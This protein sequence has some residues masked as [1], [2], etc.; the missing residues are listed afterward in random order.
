MKKTFSVFQNK[1]FTK[2]FIAAVTSHLGTIV[3]MTAFMFYLLE[4]FSSQPFYATFTEMMYSAPTLFVFFLTGVVA[5]RMDRQKVAIYADLICAILSFTL[6]AAVLTEWMPLVF[7]V[8]F[9][10]SGIA[11]FFDPAEKSLVQGILQEEEYKTAAGLNQMVAGVFN[12]FATG[13]GLVAYWSLGVQGAIIADGI[14]FLVSAFLIWS[15][16]IDQEARLPNGS[17]SWKELKV[18]FIFQDFKDG[19]LYILNHKLLFAII[20]GFFILGIV[21]GGLSVM[22][23]YILKYKL[24]PNSYEQWAVVLGIIFGISMIVGSILSSMLVYKIKLY[25]ALSLGL[26]ISGAFLM[27]G[28]IAPT[29]AWF[30]VGSVFVALT[31]PLANIAIGGWLPSIV[32]KKMM[33]RVES[34]ITPLMMASHTATLGIISVGFPSWFTISQ[35][36]YA[37][38]GALL[39]VGVGYYLILPKLS[40]EYDEKKQNLTI[41]I[42][43]AD[44]VQE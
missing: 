27:L 10:R 32:D 24:A 16:Q 26:S 37:C 5:D 39:F 42:P 31:I 7:F 38:G 34:W 2:V 18:K 29:L 25:T 22:P 30:L 43:V 9:L 14:T 3:G 23:M 41:G 15:C 44:V 1:N 12:L 36:F 8:L 17:H 40:R 21:N 33:G 19:L 11:K 13:I 35:I 4:R 28:G 6:V 20:T